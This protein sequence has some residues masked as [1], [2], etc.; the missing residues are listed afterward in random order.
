MTDIFYDSEKLENHFLSPKDNDITPLIKDIHLF[1]DKIIQKTKPHSPRLYLNEKTFLD[2]VSIPKKG[3][4]KEKLAKKLSEAFEGCILWN[5]PNAIFNITPTP[6]FCSVAANTVSSLLNPNIL[7]D[8]TGGKILTYE[9]SVVRHFS[10][11]AGYDIK[12]SGGFFVSGGKF[13]SLYALRIG[14]LKALPSSKKEGITSK[15]NIICSEQ[16][17]YTL[18]SSC[19]WLGIGSDSLIKIKSDS[20]GK[21][22]IPDLKKTLTKLLANNEK[23]GGIFLTGGNTTKF[24]VD[25]VKE[26]FDL[27]AYLIGKFKLKYTPHIHLDSVIGWLWL[28]HPQNEMISKEDKTFSEDLK[29]GIRYADSF[30]IDFHKS[31][32][33]PYISSAIIVK[34]Q[35]DFARISGEKEITWEPFGNN[36]VQFRT[37][38][39]SRAGGAILSAWSILTYLGKEGMQNYLIKYLQLTKIIRKQL[40]KSNYIILNKN[41]GGF[42]TIILPKQ[43]KNQTIQDIYKM[44]DNDVDRLNEELVE[45]YTFL[46]KNNR[47]FMNNP[48][49]GFV[50]QY[51]KTINGKYFNALRFQTNSPFLD[52][53]NIIEICSQLE[54]VLQIKRQT[55]ERPKTIWKQPK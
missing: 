17:H 53:K 33:A 19:E 27:R 18:E 35:N 49:I 37:L 8:F 55:N 28:Y 51:D 4:S 23:I 24:N 5:Q 34:E 45:F 20:K 15:I 31:G 30:G 25:D 54:N 22:S 7:M 6:L 29:E 52:D 39:H 26:V 41:F 36:F 42:S 9:R 10:Q 16:A 14:I 21:I 48:Y 12:K 46:T 1:W 50:P 13:T 2:M 38:E 11:L 44:N 43:N 47:G 3:L 32:L 40:K